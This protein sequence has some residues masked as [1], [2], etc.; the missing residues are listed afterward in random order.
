MQD[1]FCPLTPVPTNPHVQVWSRTHVVFQ[2]SSD[3][4]RHQ[5][6]LMRNTSEFSVCRT[7]KSQV[8][9]MN[10]D[11]Q[12]QKVFPEDSPLKTT[13]T[14]RVEVRWRR[15]F[16]RPHSVA[17]VTLVVLTAHLL[18][19]HLRTRT[20]RPL[21]VLAARRS[22]RDDPPCSASPAFIRSSRRKVVSVQIDQPQD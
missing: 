8:N 18:V 20:L 13:E 12:I 5:T 22:R 16:C 1:E 10:E 14:V 7:S 19:P 2:K 9:R 4:C 17:S 11:A 3:V 6:S 15:V 21:L